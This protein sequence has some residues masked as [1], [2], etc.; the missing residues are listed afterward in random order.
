MAAIHGAALG[1][2]RVFTATSGHGTLR[3]MEMFPV[4]AGARLPVVSAFM[5]RGIN[6]PLSIQPDNLEV[7]YMLDTGI[8]MLHA[9][10]S[11]DICDMISQAFFMIA[12]KPEVHIPVGVFVDGFFVT[13]TRERVKIAPPD[14]KL[15]PYSSYSAPVPVMKSN[16][17]SYAAHAS[18]QQEYLAAMEGGNKDEK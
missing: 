17:I 16:F 18:W 5:M 11:Q 4:W 10:N 14:I 8:I 13:H 1:G 7:A 12:E 6:S 15:P 9:E 2:G 3:A